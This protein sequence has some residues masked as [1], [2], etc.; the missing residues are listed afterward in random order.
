MLKQQMNTMQLRHHQQEGRCLHLLPYVT[1]LPKLRACASCVISLESENHADE[2][3]FTVISYYIKH[4]ISSSAE[5]G[6][7]KR[8]LAI[9]W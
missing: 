5:T 4:L 7:G 1:D 3:Y 9:R 8:E 6:V 2:A